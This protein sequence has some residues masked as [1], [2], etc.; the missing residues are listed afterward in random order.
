MRLVQKFAVKSLCDAIAASERP[1]AEPQ[2]PAEV[3]FDVDS[4]VFDNGVP[5]GGFAHLFLR[6]DGSYTFS[7]HFRDSGAPGFKIGI[8]WGVKDCAGRLYTF[9]G[10]GEVGGT[11]TAG[12]RDLDSTTDG[13]NDAIAQHWVDLAR[14]TT[15]SVLK[16]EANLDLAAIFDAV[17]KAVGQVMEIIAVVG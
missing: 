15:T 9:Q 7:F 8:V 14:N 6:Q 1:P 5:V 3:R 11:L 4:I 10:S 2:L 12:P 17:K 16:A 13:R